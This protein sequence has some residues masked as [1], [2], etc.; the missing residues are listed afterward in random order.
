[1]II[2]HELFMSFLSWIFY[3]V[4]SFFIYWWLKWD[5]SC[6]RSLLKSAL[7]TTNINAFSVMSLSSIRFRKST[8]IDPRIN[9]NF[10]SGCTPISWSNTLDYINSQFAAHFSLSLD[11][12]FLQCVIIE[13]WFPFDD[14]MRKKE[15]ANAFHFFACS[16]IWTSDEFRNNFKNPYDIRMHIREMKWHIKLSNQFFFY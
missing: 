7:I 14:E 8:L 3:I 2:F 6:C 16:F 15:I 13:Y 10:Y 4:F 12:F 9:M 11:F 5:S 1:M